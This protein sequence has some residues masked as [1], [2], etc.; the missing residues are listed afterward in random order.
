LTENKTIRSIKKE[1]NVEYTSNTLLNI[2]ENIHN[3]NPFTDDPCEH[4]NALIQKASK[5]IIIYSPYIIHH[6]TQRELER[7]AEKK[8][9]IYAITK[10]I[11]QHE[12]AFTHGLMREKPDIDSTFIIIDH[13][14]TSR[15]GIWF[16]GALSP[17]TISEP[18]IQLDKDQIS[19]LMYQFNHF[20]WQSHS[21]ELN[22][23]KF[24][25]AKPRKPVLN[26]VPPETHSILRY[27]KISTYLKNETLL[28]LWVDESYPVQLLYLLNGANQITLK[29]NDD[30][31]K[32]DISSSKL[33]YG[34]FSLPFSYIKTPIQTIVYR[35]DLGIVLHPTQI[36]KLEKEMTP[37][38]WKYNLS[39]QISD[40]SFDILLNEDTWTEAHKK[41]IQDEIEVTLPDYTPDSFS[42]WI[43]E[44]DQND[45]P[46][47]N[48][49]QY[50]SKKIKY[51]WTYHPPFLPIDAKKSRLYQMWT[52][53]ETT[54]NTEISELRNYISQTLSL[55]LESNPTILN[56]L[57]ETLN[58]ILI[59]P[60]HEPSTLNIIP[61]LENA[62]TIIMN[63]LETLRH[64]YDKNKNEME[65]FSNK[66]EPIHKY[67][68][69]KKYSKLTPPPLPLPS[70]GQLFETKQNRYLVIQHLDQYPIVDQIKNKYNAKIVVNKNE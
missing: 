31:K 36:E 19:G 69:S 5:T 39:K 12:R 18:L 13:Q 34:H 41:T 16:A 40:I 45:H 9:R 59:D 51:K 61:I 50:L 43:H 29:I 28:E 32:T 55:H 8:I 49:Q 30:L 23:G 58:E 42:D 1:K 3:T 67:L 48:T 10:E 70:T 21:R 22:N 54:V 14:S 53:Y 11:K 62:H 38:P 47:I 68:K 56:K 17:K 65:V 4:A 46:E 60:N 33:I 37:F 6:K 64:S 7:A 66:V 26:P 2:W 35:K 44:L 20:F 57:S 24:I 52:D 25:D 15:S 63:T 27:E